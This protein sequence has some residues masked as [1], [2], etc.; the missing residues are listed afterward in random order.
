[1]VSWTVVVFG[2]VAVAC[3]CYAG[4]RWGWQELEVLNPQGVAG[5]VLEQ[6]GREESILARRLTIGLLSGA[7]VAVGVVLV[8]LGWQLDGPA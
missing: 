7:M 1:M 3:G 2:V 6:L 5:F 8:W 4:Y